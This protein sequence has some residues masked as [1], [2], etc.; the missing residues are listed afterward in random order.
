MCCVIICGN[1]LC[2]WGQNPPSQQ[3]PRSLQPKHPARTV[4]LEEIGVNWNCIRFW[5][6]NLRGVRQ[7]GRSVP[8]GTGRVT[9]WRNV[10][11]LIIEISVGSQRQHV[12]KDAHW[13]SRRSRADS[14]TSPNVSL[15]LFL[16]CLISSPCGRFLWADAVFVKLLK[17]NT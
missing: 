1:M 11:W 12:I 15:L 16:L 10:H 6:R 14:F 17:A 9:T 7:T 5:G 13:R 8:E 3:S 4:C 2:I